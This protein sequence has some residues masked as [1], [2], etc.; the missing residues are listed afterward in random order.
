MG[1]VTCQ[2]HTSTSASTLCNRAGV[3]PG[4][5]P[6]LL[7]AHWMAVRPCHRHGFVLICSS[8]LARWFSLLAVQFKTP[9]GMAYAPASAAFRRVV[10][11]LCVSEAAAARAAAAVTGEAAAPCGGNAGPAGSA[12]SVQC[13]TVPGCVQLVL[14]VQGAD[15]MRAYQG[16]RAMEEQAGSGCGAGSDAAA[17]A[18]SLPV[19]DRLP[20]WLQPRVLWAA[21]ARAAEG[22]AMRPL[23]VPRVQCVTRPAQL[24]GIVKGQQQQATEGD[25]SIQ[26]AGASE[27]GAWTRPPA[28][29]YAE[30]V[31]LSTTTPA[32]QRSGTGPGRMPASR[33]TTGLGA[34]QQHGAQD[35]EEGAG[36]GAKPTAPADAV[37]ELFLPPQLLQC[38]PGQQ[39]VLAGARGLPAEGG[40]THGSIQEESERW[41]LVVLATAALGERQG[42]QLPHLQLYPAAAS[43]AEAVLPDHSSRRGA[44]PA[45]HW[46]VPTAPA[47]GGL[48]ARA[49][50]A[51]MPPHGPSAPLRLHLPASLL[52]SLGPMA[53]VA[54]A[55]KPPTRFPAAQG[56]PYE[57]APAAPARAAATLCPTASASGSPAPPDTHSY[58][59]GSDAEPLPRC[60]TGCGATG[61]LLHLHVLAVPRD[62][63]AAAALA[64]EPLGQ[65]GTYQCKVPRLGCSGAPAPHPTPL[66]HVGR[67]SP[68][69]DGGSSGHVAACCIPR[70]TLRA[71]DGSHGG[72]AGALDRG[73]AGAAMVVETAAASAAVGEPTAP[74]QSL[75]QAVW[76]GTAP[77]LLAPPRP[78]GELAALWERMKREVERQGEG[79]KGAAGAG[80]AAEAGCEQDTTACVYGPGRFLASSGVAM[81]HHMR[82]LLRDLAAAVGQ[83]GQGQGQGAEDAAHLRAFLQS[84]G[85]SGCVEWMD[86]AAGTACGG[87]GV[88]SGSV[89]ADTVFITPLAISEYICVRGSIDITAD[90]SSAGGGSN[91]AAG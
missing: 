65:Q 37:V 9:P 53:T 86:E 89:T 3:R 64:P 63:P 31:T 48:A 27:T 66:F 25:T 5:H 4:Y 35:Q 47:G 57:Q 70:A 43:H 80:A 30:P 50:A 83:Q 8:V 10:A 88:E 56:L 85:M 33:R 34:A 90:S 44:V 23:T 77:L 67:G 24:Q 42:A 7:A 13:L 19:L 60:G 15:E 76:L 45:A 22:L 87:E 49:A 36:E 75:P 28:L 54:A 51:G 11:N 78:A 84:Q 72:G 68:E 82:P 61:A 52:R 69:P 74:C 40:A 81:Q 16:T 1:S 59:G 58:Q 32:T 20:S 39:D 73:S 38:V 21:V 26:R 62:C 17:V 6:S 14:V 46:T 2:V 18:A 79:R 55:A 91:T 41:R 29:L 71:S 12:L